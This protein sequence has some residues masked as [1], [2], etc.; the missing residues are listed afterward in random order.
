MDC[1]YLFL[2]SFSQPWKKMRNSSVS[3]ANFPYKPICSQ[4]KC[5]HGKI[6]LPMCWFCP[7]IAPACSSLIFIST[8]LE[9]KQMEHF[10]G[11]EI[12]HPNSGEAKYLFT[13]TRSE[14][15]IPPVRVYG[16]HKFGRFHCHCAWKAKLPLLQGGGGWVLGNSSHA[17]WIWP[18]NF[19]RSVVKPTRTPLLFEPDFRDSKTE[20][21]PYWDPQI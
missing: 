3:L 18:V 11:R 1:F 9:E 13:N 17:S 8:H 20:L 16:S 7:L 6:M 15:P 12:P 5:K 14:D 2:Y 10:G 4:G 19:P 21:Q